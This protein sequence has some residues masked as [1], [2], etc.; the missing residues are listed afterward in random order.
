MERKKE[1]NL[2]LFQI[3]ITFFTKVER[4]ILECIQK[5]K[6]PKQGGWRDGSGVKST[7]CSPRGPEF[8]SQ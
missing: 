8:N 4:K 3:P 7:D 6:R 5:H 1:K 2:C